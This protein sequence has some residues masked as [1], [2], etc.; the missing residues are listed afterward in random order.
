MNKPIASLEVFSI[1]PD[2]EEKPLVIEIGAPEKKSNGEWQCAWEIQNLYTESHPA[3][4]D[5]A[6]HS[7]VLAIRTIEQL[8]TYYIEDGGRLFHEKGGDELPVSELVPRWPVS[9]KAN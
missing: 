8:L 6:W 2:G 4:S 9:Y 3:V 7:L 1:S 5:G